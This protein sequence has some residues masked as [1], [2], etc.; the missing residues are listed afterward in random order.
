MQEVKVKTNINAT[1]EIR[2][3]QRDFIE[4]SN[5][6]K[7]ME[8]TQS[9]SFQSGLIWYRGHRSYLSLVIDRIMHFTSD[10]TIVEWFAYVIDK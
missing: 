10:D 1:L 8:N 6:L 9:T 4:V 3:L 2:R 7:R 5:N